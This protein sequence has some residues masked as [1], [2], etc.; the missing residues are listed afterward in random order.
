VRDFK[1]ATDQ[2][3]NRFDSTQLATGDVQYRVDMLSRFAGIVDAAS[4]AGSIYVQRKDQFRASERYRTDDAGERAKI[5][6]G[7]D[8]G[9][10]DSVPSKVTPARMD[11]DVT[12][13]YRES[14]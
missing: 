12:F 6:G 10:L 4:G 5:A 2:L 1:R 9:P 3:R 14:D 11:A 8:R 7:E 13:D